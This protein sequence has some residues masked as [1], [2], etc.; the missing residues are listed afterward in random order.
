M[1]FPINLVG[2][3]LAVKVDRPNGAIKLPDW[4]RNLSGTVIAAGPRCSK[5]VVLSSR[6]I[7]GAAVGM[8]ATLESED[9]R[10]LKESDLD[11]VYE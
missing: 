8:D 9:I 11:G 6:V 7:F 2:E 3:L 5:D 1:S 4:K 10:I